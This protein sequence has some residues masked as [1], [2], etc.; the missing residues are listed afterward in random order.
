MRSAKIN[1]LA[2]ALAGFACA[3]AVLAAQTNLGVLDSGRPVPYFIED[4]SGVTGYRP[5]DR[6]LARMAFDAWS[7]ETEG[8]LRFTESRTKA[9]ALVSLEWADAEAGAFG[10]THRIEIDGKPGA[11]VV[12]MPDVRQ[13]GQPLASRATDDA[14]LRETIVYLTCVHEIGHAVGMP[15]TRNF[16]DIMYYFGYGGDIVDY[17]SRYRGRLQTRADIARNTGLS[18]GDV[19]FLRSLYPKP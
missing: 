16:E 3:A 8:R 15:H 1:I 14:L 13:L 10:V 12:V 19:A 17:F 18:S 4:G 9:E 6:E 5:S 11:V 7:R 2:C